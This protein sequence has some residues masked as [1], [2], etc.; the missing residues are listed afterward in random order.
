MS[1]TTIPHLVLKELKHYGIT[2]DIP[3][4][5]RGDLEKEHDYL[6]WNDDGPELPV[7]HSDIW[8]IV[9][10][11]VDDLEES[12]HGYFDAETAILTIYDGVSDD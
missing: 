12:G 8:N 11:H 1:K 6:V 2:Y 10:R 4:S 5:F 7:M 3:E 9:C